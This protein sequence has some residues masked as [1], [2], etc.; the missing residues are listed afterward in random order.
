MLHPK[1]SNVEGAN[2]ASAIHSSVECSVCARTGRYFFFSFAA[3]ESCLH[4]NLQFSR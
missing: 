1:M 3:N 4:L 2:V